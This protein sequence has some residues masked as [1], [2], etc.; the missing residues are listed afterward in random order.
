MEFAIRPAAPADLPVLYR[1]CLA[2]GDAGGDATRLYADPE[3]LGHY[4]AA[5]YA[6][7]EPESCFVLTAGGEVCGYVLGTRDAA[8]FAAR[9][10]REWFPAMRARL[11]RPREDDI[12]NDATLIRLIHRG[13]AVE[14]ELCEFPAELHIDLLPEAQGRGWGWRLIERFCA[15]VGSRGSTGVHLG[16]SE[17]NRGAIAFYERIG[18]TLLCRYPDWRAYGRRWAETEGGFAT[19]RGRGWPGS[20]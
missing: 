14:P 11:P 18:F 10:E 6:V 12:S 8:A 1:I 3:L 17:R 15:A 20:E 19:E 9:A 13:F 16:V 5:P 4:F 7:L 2:T